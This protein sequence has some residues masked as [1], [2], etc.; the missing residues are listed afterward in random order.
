M[1][2]TEMD[3]TEEALALEFGDSPIAK[4]GCDGE[5]GKRLL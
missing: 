2:T 4:T 5:E 3:S 1:L